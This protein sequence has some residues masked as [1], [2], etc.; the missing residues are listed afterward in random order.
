LGE[1]LPK[2]N[3]IFFI[4]GKT[5]LFLIKFS[6]N[7]DIT[8]SRML[9]IGGYITKLEKGKKKEKLFTGCCCCCWLV[10]AIARLSGK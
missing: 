3:K 4:I 7:E 9:T 8:Y 5:S 2:R 10:G 6:P 1:K